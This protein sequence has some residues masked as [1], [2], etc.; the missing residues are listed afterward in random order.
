MIDVDQPVRNDIRTHGNIQKI[1]TGQ[2]YDHATG[3]L[4]SYPYLKKNCK[5]TA[6]GL[7]N[8]QA[9][10]ADL[11]AIHQI[12]FM[13]NLECAGNITMFFII[14]EVKKNFLGFLTR[15]YKST[16]NKFYNI[17]LVFYFSINIQ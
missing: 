10:D 8:Q 9:L 14:K 2:G 7:R 17:Y 13:R 4:L 12:N 16:V 6:I 1:A 5:L 11:K 3:C 15:N